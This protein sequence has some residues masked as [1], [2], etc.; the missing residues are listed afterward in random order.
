M[1]TMRVTTPMS[2]P[3]GGEMRSPIFDKGKTT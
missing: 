3:I 2:S 1:Q